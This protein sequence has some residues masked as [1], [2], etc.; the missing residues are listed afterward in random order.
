MALLDDLKNKVSSYFKEP[1]KVEETTIVPGTDYSKLTFGNKGLVSEFSFLFVDIRKSSELHDKY[2]YANA[3]K[4]YQSFHDI[5]LR[6]I[7]VFDGKVRAFDGDRIMGVF[8]GGSKRTNAT[9]AAMKI[10]WAIT[11]VLNPNLK[12]GLNIGCGI[13]VGKTLI[14]KV[15]KGRDINNN[16][17]IWIGKACNYAS[18]LTQSANNTIIISKS[19]YDSIAA[20]AKYKDADTK[21]INMWTVKQITLKNKTV[22]NVYESTYTWGL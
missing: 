2:G 19:V 21:Q 11:N 12:E 18:H 20:E 8:A 5:C 4:I 1:Y 13:D 16:D 17:L 9:K 15:G 3:A 10:R 7:E 14:T 22:I 6:I